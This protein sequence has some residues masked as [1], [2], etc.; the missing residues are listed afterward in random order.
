[1][2][3]M[4][5]PPVTSGILKPT[6]SVSQHCQLITCGVH[7]TEGFGDWSTKNCTLI[8]NNSDPKAV[9][10]C[11]HFTNFA[12]LLV[13]A[14]SIS[15]LYVFALLTNCHAVFQDPNPVE[16]TVP[17]EVEHFL[18]VLSYIGVVI[19]TICLIVTVLTYLTSK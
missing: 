5:T 14:D 12:I 2:A 8:S 3:Q 1:M 4:Q 10:Q 7:C 18:S 16:R 6:V 15:V 13:S 17:P 9:C 11:T 19:S